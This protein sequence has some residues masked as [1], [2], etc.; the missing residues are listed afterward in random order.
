MGGFTAGGLKLQ[1]SVASTM[2]SLMPAAAPAGPY[3]VAIMGAI[4]FVAEVVEWMSNDDTVV[5]AL[6]KIAEAINHIYF[7]LDVLDSRL[8]ELVDQVAIESNRSTLRDLKDYLDEVQDVQSQLRNLPVDVGTLVTIAD[9][10]GL[11][12]DKFLRDDYDIWRWTDVV[13]KP[14]L[15]GNGNPMI[16]PMT[17]Q[18]EEAPALNLQ[19]FK[20]LPTLPVYLMAVATWLAARE[21]VVQLGGRERLDDDAGRV[22]RHLNAVT[23]RPVFNE[24]APEEFYPDGS[25]KSTPSPQSLPEHIQSLIRAMIHSSNKY[26]EDRVCHFWFDVQN[27][28]T[29]EQTHG[30]LFDLLMESNDVLCTCDPSLV[31]SP[32]AEYEAEEAAGTAALE[33]LRSTLERVFQSGSVRKPFVGTFPTET[34]AKA[35]YYGVN[36]PGELVW[37]EHMW[38]SGQPGAPVSLAGPRKLADGWGQ[39]RLVLPAGDKGIYAVHQDGT[40][41]WYRHE[42]AFDGTTG[43]TGPVVVG[44]GWNGY[45]KIIAGGNGVLYGMEPDGKLFWYR[46]DGFE[47]GGDVTTWRGRIE[48]GSGWTIFDRIFSA[49]DGTL[50]GVKPDGTLVWYFHKGVNQG[51][52]NWE[53]PMEVGSGWQHFAHI[54]GA[55]EGIIYAVQPDGQVFWYHHE[56]WKTGGEIRYI[57]IGGRQEPLSLT[58]IPYWKGPVLV[59]DER[60]RYRHMFGVLPKPLPP[61]GGVH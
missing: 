36:A 1:S 13:L 44:W 48:V 59:T 31:G 41:H 50:Y 52:Y 7:L 18:Y 2:V 24:Y 15:D 61:G 37:F 39:Y 28:M 25:I 54:F 23:V 17:G 46:H 12:A 43:L 51:T 5:K 35:T 33:A 19:Q 56:T 49:G 47:S 55:G 4:A 3:V 14:V 29:G 8:D 32:E 27:W 30:G 21:R 38:H 45:A 57:T 6:Q 10:A 60:S 34:Y 22:Q 53:A 16:N 42:G 9:R 11:I 26:P 58:P 40:L 20:N